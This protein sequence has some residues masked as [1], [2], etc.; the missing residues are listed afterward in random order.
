MGQCLTSKATTAA[1]RPSGAAVAKASVRCAP[2]VTAVVWGA[3]RS[4]VAGGSAHPTAGEGENTLAP[5]LPRLSEC[6]RRVH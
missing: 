4:R 6:H 5:V 2:R 1:A 3:Q